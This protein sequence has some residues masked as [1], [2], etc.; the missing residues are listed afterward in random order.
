MRG[1]GGTARGLVHKSQEA[2]RDEQS[3]S[4]VRYLALFCLLVLAGGRT[5]F[6]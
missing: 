5:Y 3:P 6:H 2:K 1:A 4:Y